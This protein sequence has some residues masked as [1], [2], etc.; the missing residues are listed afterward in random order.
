M[1]QMSGKVAIVTGAS[2]SSLTTNATTS[3]AEAILPQEN[4]V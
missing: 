4:S 2:T 1:G 3:A